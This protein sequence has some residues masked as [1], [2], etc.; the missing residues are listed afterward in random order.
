M[1]DRGDQEIIAEAIASVARECEKN[2]IPRA[3]ALEY[4]AIDFTW[5]DSQIDVQIIPS[6][7]R[8][9]WAFWLRPHPGQARTIDDAFEEIGRS[10]WP[11]STPRDRLIYLCLNRINLEL[12][13]HQ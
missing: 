1:I 9:Q 11:Q 10:V 12:G 8:L 6:P 13:L 5:N 3:V 2:S 4:M 7:R